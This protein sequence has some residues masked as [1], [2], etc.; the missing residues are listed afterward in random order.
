MCVSATGSKGFF[1]INHSPKALSKALHMSADF[2]L[3]KPQRFDWPVD[4][5]NTKYF[6]TIGSRE[7]GAKGRAK[8]IFSYTRFIR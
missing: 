8:L 6:L 2:F 5:K 1:S 3:L 7:N 4:I